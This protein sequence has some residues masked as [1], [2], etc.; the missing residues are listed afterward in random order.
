MNQTVAELRKLL[1]EGKIERG[2]VG[3]VPVPD[4]LSG[5]LPGG[6]S[7]QKP[8]TLAPTIGATS[9]AMALAAPVTRTG[10]WVAVVDW[11]GWGWAAAAD[12]GMRLGQVAYIPN[13]QGKFAE[14]VAALAPGMELI[15]A[16]PPH[17]VPAKIRR[18]LETI[19]WQRHCGLLIVG[20]WPG[21]AADLS[22]ADPVWHGAADGFG[23]LKRRSMTVRVRRRTGAAAEVAVWLP[24]PD[25]TISTVDPAELDAAGRTVPGLVPAPYRTVRRPAVDPAAR[26]A[27]L[28]QAAQRGQGAPP[29]QPRTLRE[30]AAGYRTQPNSGSLIRHDPPDEPPVG[31]GDGCGFGDEPPRPPATGGRPPRDEPFADEPPPRSADPAVWDPVWDPLPVVSDD[32]AGAGV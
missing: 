3:G 20:D 7:R 16:R 23:R 1:D 24:G 28:A 30:W 11:P 10:G 22:T 13:T 17:P 21:A 27:L 25:G 31:D 5:L 6:L 4:C 15:V 19:A 2:I 32:R 14:V 26:A 29:D 9:L 12:H 18:R 8:T